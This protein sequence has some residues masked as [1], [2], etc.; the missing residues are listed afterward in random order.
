MVY[1]SSSTSTTSILAEKKHEWISMNGKFM[2]E[3]PG[4]CVTRITIV[5]LPPP[6]TT[7][8]LRKNV[9]VPTLLWGENANLV[10][11]FYL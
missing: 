6:K 8:L 5:S 9:L 4:E 1:T 10:Y 3:W 2:N 7:K 11:G